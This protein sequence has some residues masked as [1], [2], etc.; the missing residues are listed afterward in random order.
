MPAAEIVEADLSRVEHQQAVVELTDAYA[1]DPM[2]NGQPL[3]DE[4]RD[5]LIAGLRRHPTTLV[6]LGYVEGQAVGIATCF[7]GFSTFAARPLINVHDV[8]VLP[9][10]RGRGLGRR[11]LEAV[12]QK[13]RALRCCKLTLEV[14][15]NNRRARGLY[16][17]LGF[18]QAQYA[19]GAGGALYYAK[20]LHA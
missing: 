7:I 6:F 8:A 17:S 9:E 13:A 14:L 15:E 19:E 20:S 4:V 16:E 18:A 10:F 3:S 11:L 5:S 12:E 1:R 2:G